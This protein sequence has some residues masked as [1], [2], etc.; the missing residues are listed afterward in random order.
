MTNQI[1][2][3]EEVLGHVAD[4]LEAHDFTPL[5][6]QYQQVIDDMQ[7]DIFT[8]HEFI[9]ELAWRNQRLYIEALSAYRDANPFQVVHGILAR[10]LHAFAEYVDHVP[11]T[12]LFGTPNLC[13]RWRRR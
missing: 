1:S 4:L 12:D 2:L 11:S 6:D 10:K 9:Q 3:A 8:S 7:K 13:A 5:E